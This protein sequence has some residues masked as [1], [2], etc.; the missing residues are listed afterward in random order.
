MLA[1]GRTSLQQV[2]PCVMLLIVPRI[3]RSATS[4]TFSKSIGHG[5]ASLRCASTFTVYCTVAKR[6]SAA[7]MGALLASTSALPSLTV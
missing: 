6:R 2:L 5:C 3:Q 1:N 7:D 4:H